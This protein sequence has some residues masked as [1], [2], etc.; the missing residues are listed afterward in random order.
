MMEERAA[1]HHFL[2]SMLS[3]IYGTFLDRWRLSERVAA[4]VAPFFYFS[5]LNEKELILSPK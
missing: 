3:N 2:V 4:S 5:A 1:L